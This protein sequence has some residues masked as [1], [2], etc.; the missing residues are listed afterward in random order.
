[1][2]DAAP[3]PA[4]SLSR[5]TLSQH[6]PPGF[7]AFEKPHLLNILNSL[8]I[9]KLDFIENI[10]PLVQVLAK[11]VDAFARS[12]TD[13]GKARVEPHR[14][15]IRPGTLPRPA[16]LRSIKDPKRRQFVEKEV[17][18]LVELGLIEPA[19][20]S[21]FCSAVTIAE[22][23]DGTF[24]LCIDYRAL[25]WLTIPDH[26]PLPFTADLLERIGAKKYFCSLDLLWGYW[27]IPM[28]PD[29]MDK[30]TFITHLGTFR[31]KV[32]PFGLTGAPAT[33]QRTMDTLFKD[34]LG[35]DTLVYLDDIILYTDTLP[36]LYSAID[37]A[38]TIL[39]THGFK[40]KTPK[41]HISREI[42]F[43]GFH[44]CN[45]SLSVGEGKLSKLVGWPVP[46][47]VKDVQSFLGFAN[48]LRP[49]VPNF[50]SLA[51]PL[52]ASTTRKPFVFSEENI[53]QFNDLKKVICT[54]PPVRVP[55][56]GLPFVLE[57]DASGFGAGACLKQTEEGTGYQ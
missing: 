20:Y 8:K 16:K 5:D 24:R 31:F 14:I 55:R 22:K 30:T 51:A 2:L 50:G 44:I 54:V 26:Y 10:A 12:E 13:V 38:L 41:C 11:N 23:K 19:R 43:L 28:H 45:G 25:N 56:Q 48:F 37:N 46:S 4:D 1:V 3:V 47:S 53:V 42:E 15:P 6:I 21:D 17:R 32:M 7:P 57:T 39:R 52:H 36:E 29:D 18:K 40:C 33:F 49:L 35:L 27:E 34:R 9:D